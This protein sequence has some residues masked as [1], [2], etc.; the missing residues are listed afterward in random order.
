MRRKALAI[1][2]VQV[3]VCGD[4]FQTIIRQNKYINT[5][6]ARETSRRINETQT[7]LIDN[8]LIIHNYC[9]IDIFHYL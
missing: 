2:Y 1:K 9:I 3:A 5:L 8:P 6:I 7:R 4:I